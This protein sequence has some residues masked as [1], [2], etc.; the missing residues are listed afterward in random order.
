[1]ALRSVENVL[2]NV[3]NESGDASRSPA[4]DNDSLALLRTSM[5]RLVSFVV[6]FAAPALELRAFLLTILQR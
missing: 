3:R 2:P 1:V 6:Q 5:V 4:A